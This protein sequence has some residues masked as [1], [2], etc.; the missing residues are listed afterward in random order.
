MT[1][2]KTVQSVLGNVDVDD[3]LDVLGLQ[4]K[5]SGLGVLGLITIG[6]VIGAGAAL[7]FAPD[8]SVTRNFLSERLPKMN[9]VVDKVRSGIGS[10]T[11]EGRLPQTERG[12]GRSINS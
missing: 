1:M 10:M 5:S 7:L 4:R 2:K 12:T 9:D 6:A 8:K 3:V 11:G